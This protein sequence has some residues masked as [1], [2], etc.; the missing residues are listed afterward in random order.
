MPSKARNKWYADFKRTFGETPAGRLYR[1]NPEYRARR[2]AYAKKRW[3]ELRKDK[4]FTARR[5]ANINARNLEIKVEVLKRYGGKCRCCSEKLIL[6]LTIDHIRGDGAT[7]RRLIGGNRTKSQ[8]YRWLKRNNF[9]TGFRVL[10][11]NCNSGRHI[12]GGVCP[13][14][15]KRPLSL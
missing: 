14:K 5:N 8:I 11:W 7:H 13:H 1:L 15:E 4:E 10:C 2:R 9:P 3:L 12:N 6:L